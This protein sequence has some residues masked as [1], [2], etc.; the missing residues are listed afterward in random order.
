VIN[1][2]RV[3]THDLPGDR[4]LALIRDAAFSLFNLE[5]DMG[6]AAPGSLAADIRIARGPVASLVGIDTS[7]SI[8]ERTRARASASATANFLVYFVRQGGSWFQ[9]ARAQS[10]QTRAGSVVVG[11]QDSAYK[12][13]AARGQD[14]RFHVL[15]VPPHLFHFAGDRIRQGGFQVVPDHAPLGS[16]LSSYL[17]D[18]CGEFA[19]LDAASSSASLRALDHLLAAAL[20]G[21]DARDDGL[22]CTVGD[23]RMRAAMRYIQRNLESPQL[24]PAAIARHLCIS[25]RQLHR[26]FEADGKTVTAEV[27]RVRLE[28]ASGL[29]R[30]QPDMPVTQVAFS[31]GFDSLA[32]FYRAFKAGFGIT[33]SEARGN[34][35]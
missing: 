30:T 32:T 15:S 26:T 20:D 2:T 28:R 8:V 25:T 35:H 5:V 19:G 1:D 3:S 11:C 31:C 13:G 23:A 6:D 10:F 21:R 12:A 18:L 7:W 4:K 24:S 33:A 27:R 17:G 9:N 29:L 34:G 16:L 14:W 22:A